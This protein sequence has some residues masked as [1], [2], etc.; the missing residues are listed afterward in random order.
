MTPDDVVVTGLG[1]VTP[2]GI[3]VDATWDRLLV[4]ESTATTDPLLAGLAVD[5]SCRVPGFD[6]AA[7]LGRRL[8]VRLDTVSKYALVAAREAV[9]DAGLADGDWDPARTAVVIGVGT[10]SFE[11][12]EREFG[13]V[14]EGLP[15]LV[16]PLAI[17]RSVPSMVAGEVALDLGARGPSLAVSTA[18][19]SGTTALGVARDLLRAGGCDIALAGGAE[20][21]RTRIPAI[22]FHQMKA[23]SRRCA[24]P[25]AASRPFDSDRDG[26]VLGEGAGL[27]VLERAGHARARGARVRARLAGYGA[28]NDAHHITVPHPDGEG[29]ARSL[30]TA[31]ADAD[32]APHDIGHVNAHGTG[33]RENDLTESRAL[34]AVFPRVPPVTS[35]KGALGHALGAS[36]GIQAVCTVR[37][38]ETGLVPPTANLDHPDPAI[39]LDVVRK[40]ARR[41][42]PGA[43]VSESFG[44]GGH[45]AVLVLTRA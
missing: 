13:R 6:A 37:A 26:F 20:A 40:E 1:L 18:C 5:I 45:N 8:D 27:L 21:N 15:H 7:L 22:C 23:L 4:P 43:A 38:L 11:R 12:Y 2:A 33:T 39:E 36:G 34:R 30:R 32:L 42:A 9:A 41:V 35:L 44:F 31:L 28:S 25:A 16:S 19:A 29:A 24:D 17:V 10:C 3:G 14:A